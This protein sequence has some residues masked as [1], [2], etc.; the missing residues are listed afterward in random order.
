MQ[1]YANPMMMM[2]AAADSRP[3]SEATAEVREGARSWGHMNASGDGPGP[4]TA[5][6]CTGDTMHAGKN[7]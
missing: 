2:M 3:T 5:M 6:P 4:S 1:T 7:V